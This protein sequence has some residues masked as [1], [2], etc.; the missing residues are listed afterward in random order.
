MFRCAFCF[1]LF[2]A[3]R[4]NLKSL[5]KYWAR[6]ARSDNLSAL[7]Y[8][9]NAQALALEHVNKAQLADL[10]VYFFFNPPCVFPLFPRTQ[11]SVCWTWHSSMD[12]RKVTELKSFVQ[13]CES[14]PGILHLPEMG[15]F[16]TWLQTWVWMETVDPVW[17]DYHECCIKKITVVLMFKSVEKE[18]NHVFCPAHLPVKSTDYTDSE[19][20]TVYM[21]AKLNWSGRICVFTCYPRKHQYLQN[22]KKMVVLK[23]KVSNLLET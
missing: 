4:I 5:L 16:R 18:A 23:T 6:S 10:S 17:V 21:E 8:L 13:L 1:I 19:I 11:R 22:F 14:N 7:A 2:R 3:F 12:P 20:L 15:F 9:A